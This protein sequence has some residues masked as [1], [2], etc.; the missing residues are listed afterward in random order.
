MGPGRFGPV[1]Q[2]EDPETHQPVVIRTF[3]QPMDDEEQARLLAALTH[4][5]ETPLDHPSIARP[6]AAGIDN[7]SPYLVHTLL[8]GVSLDAFVATHGPQ[9]LPDVVVRM[10]QLA[11][12]IDFAAA[13]GVH[14][15]ALRSTDVILA[16]DS[17][18][19]SG[20][21]LMQAVHAAGLGGHDIPSWSNDVAA[22]AALAFELLYGRA[23]EAGRIRLPELASGADA[24]L[25]QDV[26]DAALGPDAA[27]RPSSAL[28]FAAALQ[29]AI[30]IAPQPQA[31]ASPTVGIADAPRTAERRAA[32]V[33]ALVAREG[34][35]DLPLR[36]EPGG[37][38]SFPPDV[39]F[40]RHD[41]PESHAAVATRPMF[42]SAPKPV[43]TRRR[44]TGVL[45]AAA[46][47]VVALGGFA[48][49]VF[50][51]QGGGALPFPDFAARPSSAQ[52]R[53]A[54]EPNPTS[55]TGAGE[56]SADPAGV[57]SS[58]AEIPQGG[59]AV[60]PGQAA[61][62]GPLPPTPE[63]ATP[64]RSV[65]AP[66]PEVNR[67]GRQDR[68][69]GEVLPEARATTPESQ[70]SGPGSLQILSRPDGAQ[71]FVDGALVGRTPLL[72]ASV[73]PGMHDVRIELPGHRRWATAVRV[74]PGTRARV[75]ASLEQ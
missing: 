71:V 52:D 46:F 42:G 33:A 32:D 37:H 59:D 9:P 29:N 27:K 38:T 21:G 4:L 28:A 66:V 50:V 11:A 19:I 65:P 40:E 43:Q 5:C 56:L 20:F 36:V 23:P 22:L 6:L 72:V 63:S 58:E 48:A 69:R 34:S 12:A 35:V 49:G 14:H 74:E 3:F 44:G 39:A 54:A 24:R 47:V 26:F 8:R 51:G 2:G 25:L 70:P 45:L 55:T 73:A 7:G 10:T 67:D 18:G 41:A 1:Y 57:V 17:T 61:I 62:P 30:A 16:R 60:S 53:V 64:D 68:E 13:A 75:A 31:Q 15:G